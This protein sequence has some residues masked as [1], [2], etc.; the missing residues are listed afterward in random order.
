[1][2]DL[3]HVFYGYC[4]R[5]TFLH[6]VQKLGDACFDV[7]GDFLAALACAEIISEGL[8]VGGEHLVGILI[9]GEE[10]PAKIDG[11]ILFHC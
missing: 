7:L 10:A 11:N 1:M 9:N 4:F 5:A 8:L 6:F 3:A 2:Y